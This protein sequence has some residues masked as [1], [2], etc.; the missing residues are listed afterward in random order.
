MNVL[1][2]IH[3]I[4][5][6]LVLGLLV[7]AIFNALSKRNSGKFEKSDKLINLFAMVFVHMQILIGLLLYFTSGKVSFV[8]G[9]MKVAQLRFFGMEH[10]MMMVI[11]AV[12]ITI[13]RRKSENSTNTRL[14]HKK[15]VTFYLIGLLIIL[16]AIP[17]P[18]LR[19]FGTGWY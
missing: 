9:W 5:R 19:N 8:S 6:W 13:G 1:V 14:K 17:W 7:F 12:L 15:I 11:A 10:L 4:S 2:S 18:G 3:S 16:A